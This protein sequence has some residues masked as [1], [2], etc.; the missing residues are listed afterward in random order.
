MTKAGFSCYGPEIW[1]FNHGNQMDSL[2]KGGMA[3]YSYI[4][5][6]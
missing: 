2:V 1:H 3:A 5:P 6:G 4:E